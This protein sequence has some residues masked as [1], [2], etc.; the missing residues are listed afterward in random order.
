MSLALIAVAGLQ[1]AF[2]IPIDDINF[3]GTGCL[4]A[5]TSINISNWEAE[6]KYSGFD[7]ANNQSKSCDLTAEL[8]ILGGCLDEA[9]VKSIIASSLIPDERALITVELL[10]DGNSYSSPA[11]VMLNGTVEAMIHEIRQPIQRFCGDKSSLKVRTNLEMLRGNHEVKIIS[12]VI[13]INKIGTPGSYSS[14]MELSPIPLGATV[15]FLLILKEL[16]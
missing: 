14:A 10:K 8:Q 15:L 11:K 6:L 3:L 1:L 12:Q 7:I 5:N 2:A 4:K 9:Y 16:Q 13:F